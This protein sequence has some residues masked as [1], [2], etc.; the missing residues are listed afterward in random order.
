MILSLDPMRCYADAD[1]TTRAQ[2]PTGS[3]G[4][5]SGQIGVYWQSVAATNTAGALRPSAS[6]FY[7]RIAQ[8]PHAFG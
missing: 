5:P 1:T 7:Q 4:G 3:L 8:N 6:W 2:A